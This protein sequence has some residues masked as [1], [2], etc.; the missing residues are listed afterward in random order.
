MTSLSMD[1]L[2]AR[3]LRA[4]PACAESGYR[5]CQ[6]MAQSSINDQSSRAL[7]TGLATSDRSR[8]TRD[9]EI[10][11]DTLCWQFAFSSRACIANLLLPDTE[12]GVRTP[13]TLKKFR[14]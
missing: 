5:F 2:D 3:L 14:Y 8:M 7:A 4:T 10:E 13:S 12:R 11:A 1:E 9:P 6:F